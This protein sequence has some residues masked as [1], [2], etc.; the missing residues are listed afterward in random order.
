MPLDDIQ[1][2]LQHCYARQAEFG[3]ESAFRFSLFLGPQR[4][5]LFAIYPDP[6]NPGLSKLDKDR[7]KKDK[8]KQREYALQG[9]LQI[10]ESE[11]PPT[12]DPAGPVTQQTRSPTVAEPSNICN[13][14]ESEPQTSAASHQNDLVRIDMGK[15]L[16]LK[17]MGYEAMGPVN[18]PN[19][20]Y[21][22]YE[23]PRATLQVLQSRSQSISAPTQTEIALGA[24]D[25]DP[26]PNVIDPAL[27][28]QAEDAEDINDPS[29]TTGGL[30]E[31]VE[32]PPEVERIV[33]PTTPL[34]A[35][36]GSA[37]NPHKTPQKQLGKR[38][39]ANLSPQTNRQ[40]R[41]NSKKKKITDDDRAAMEA[42]NIVQSG[43]R[44]RKPTR[45]Q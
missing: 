6:S 14:R 1:K 40:L 22:E 38:S 28:G 5:R 29:Q 24:I 37:P 27:L 26:V 32:M 25:P 44:R 4:K 3:P 41:G 8:G 16:M 20:G 35:E 15:M 19:D 12:A 36:A 21:P 9:L 18:G 39:Q 13:R 11:E 10:E 30:P 7:Q 2:V 34:S 23:V 31:E 45:R 33:R 43:S 42:Q 17:D